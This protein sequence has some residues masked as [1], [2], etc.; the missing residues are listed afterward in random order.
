[1]W[2]KRDLGFV[3][4]L[5]EGDKKNVRDVFCLGEKWKSIFLNPRDQIT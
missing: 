3:K 1:M 2:E 4:D 5:G